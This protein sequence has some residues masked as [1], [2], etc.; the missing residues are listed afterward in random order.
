MKF[1]PVLDR[2]VDADLNT[3]NAIFLGGA[4]AIGKSSYI[5]ALGE[6]HGTKTFTMNCNMLETK[7]DVTGIRLVPIEDSYGNKFFPTLKIMEAIAYAEAHPEE[8]P[9]LFGDELNR[10]TSG[11]VSALLTA[12]TDRTIGDITLPPNLRL[13]FA[14]NV[15]GNISMFDAATISRF[16]IYKVTPDAET[17]KTIHEGQLHPVIE[18]ILT[19]NPE[20]IYIEPEANTSFAMPDDDDD[21]EDEV[22]FNPNAA[23]VETE[24]LA[25]ITAPRTIMALNRVLVD[26][27]DDDL[28][29]ELMTLESDDEIASNL[30][31]ERI[32]G[33][34]GTTPFAYAVISKLTEK[35]T[36]V[37]T[38]NSA[39]VNAIVMPS[40]YVNFESLTDIDDIR[41]YA[42][43]LKPLIA[44][45]C[46]LFALTSSRQNAAAIVTALS[47]VITALDQKQMGKVMAN[48]S[49]I[50]KRP[51]KALMESK[52]ALAQN[53]V[54]TNIAS[55]I[56]A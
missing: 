23:F 20:F 26:E 49:M 3:G 55:M 41:N 2:L 28:M 36:G 48:Y 18:E 40:S 12:H 14:G 6:R 51:L 16:S 11:A 54:L 17:F 47:E 30:F 46:L 34:V 24:S 29:K 56:N 13:V 22:K 7:E 39:N 43:T 44:Q 38:T 9:I 50:N 42:Q 5:Q 52:S 32:F 15:T 4:S 10:T 8:N 35:L 37:S 1:G 53:P 31:E 45:E 27:W 25:Q 21:D 33:Y 19:D